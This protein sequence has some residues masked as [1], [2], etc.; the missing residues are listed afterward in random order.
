[1]NSLLYYLLFEFEYGRVYMENDATK[2][3]KSTTSPALHDLIKVYSELQQDCLESLNLEIIKKSPED[4]FNLI[5]EIR[6]GTAETEHFLTV[7]QMENVMLQ[8]QENQ[9]S[10]NLKL[11]CN[12]ILK[13][14]EANLIDKK[15]IEY[16]EKGIKLRKY[17]L[18]PRT[19]VTMIGKLP[20]TRM[21]LISSS[22]T[23]AEKLKELT[24]KKIIFPLDEAL[25]LDV[26]PFKITVQV[27]LKIAYWVQEST[28]YATAK[29]ALT[30]NTSINVNEETIRAVTNTVGKLVFRNDEATAE[31]VYNCLNSGKLSFPKIKNNHTLYL[32][33]DGALLHT[34]QKDEEGLT[35]KENKLGMAF[36]T[37]FFTYNHDNNGKRCPQV[38][39]REYI[40]LLGDTNAFKKHMFALALRNG[41]GTYRHTVLLSDGAAW[42]RNM[43]EELFPDAQQ[44]LDFFHLRKNALI[45]AKAIF[46]NDES[47][48]RPWTDRLCE[49]VKTSRIAEA[50]SKIRNLNKRQLVKSKF[51]LTRY[52]ENNKDNIDYASY[53]KKGWIISNDTI[54]SG[55]RIALQQRLNQP[56]MR[57]NIESG[58]YILTLI[59]KAKSGLW[60]QDVEEALFKYYNLERSI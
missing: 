49:L 26:L 6:Q 18:F 10:L 40:M 13:I 32:K 5:K 14:N 42:I 60:K 17:R 15:K 20:F 46:S 12:E 44:I 27:M 22:S 7:T 55:N 33:V 35:W 57:W 50:L 53:L 39:K 34:R 36:S 54:E 52:L 16:R 45:F 1:M 3:S 48:Y 4:F 11:L 2:Q 21:G 51:D 8:L 9:K 41:Y 24:S 47:K 29:K 37:E 31:K 38:G 58:Q 30:H 19:I 28:S 43:K 25:G 56:G 59:S 23:D